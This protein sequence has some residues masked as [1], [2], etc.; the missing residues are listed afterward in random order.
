MPNYIITWLY[1]ESPEDES[2]YPSVGGEASSEKFQKVYWQCVYDFYKSAL[3]TQKNPAVKYMFFTNVPNIPINIEGINICQFLAKNNVTIQRLE[4]TNKTPKDWYGAWRNQFFLFDI[5]EYLQNIEGNYLILDSD[6]FITKDLTCIFNEIEKK[7]IL[8]FDSG[9]YTLDYPINGISTKQ[10]R[11]LYK[12][13]FGE[14][15]YLEYKGG[16]FIA[17][18]SDMIPQILYEYKKL[19]NLN[20]QKYLMRE[21]KLNEEAHFLSLIYAHLGYEESVGNQYIKRMWTSVRYDNV[22]ASDI[23]LPIWHLPAEKKYGF[24]TLFQYFKTDPVEEQYL[25]YL[26][27]VVGIS[28]NR[29]WRR[30]KKAI[31]KMKEKICEYFNYT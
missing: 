12:E 19:W 22:V 17:I 16:E 29:N 15:S 10:M 2:H 20:Y 21:V 11:N 9:V 1:A 8:S 27:K 28:D 18:N 26:K 13:F 25:N 14:V 24:Q 4:L 6:C 23:E 7:K 30:T 5:L 31:G 3:L